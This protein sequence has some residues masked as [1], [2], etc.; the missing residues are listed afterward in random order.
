MGL[1]VKLF[2]V[3]ADFPDRNGRRV[4]VVRNLKHEVI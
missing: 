2:R 4:V 1:G 3:S